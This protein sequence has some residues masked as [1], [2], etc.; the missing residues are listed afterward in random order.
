MI[1]KNKLILSPGMR[2]GLFVCI[3]VFCLL[4]SALI[5]GIIMYKWPDTTSAM[6]IAT[7]IQDIILFIAP[8]IITSIF[9]TKLPADFLQLRTFPSLKSIFLTTL[10]IFLSIPAMNFI[11]HCNESISLPDSFKGIEMQLKSME[12]SSQ[13]SIEILLGFGSSTSIINLVISIL[14][15]G[16]LAGLS[17]ELFFRGALQ[18]IF[19]TSSM[20]YHSAI[21]ITALI[22]SSMHF[23]FYGFIPRLLLGAFFGYLAFWSRSLW[24]PIFA[25]T[26]NNSM[27]VI[28]TWL[29]KQ[30]TDAIDVNKIGTNLSNGNYLL[31]TISIIATTLGI[32]VLYQHLNILHRD[33]KTR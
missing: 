10:I 16:V 6:R 12:E 24:L 13:K 27:V 7:I 11:V 32:L 17:E 28:S 29:I 15:I 31:I 1:D 5:S 2:L 8:A 20:K 3:T 23:Q 33:K 25:H 26:L 22:F 9:I 21:W 19:C 30:N 14:I 18:N 4:I